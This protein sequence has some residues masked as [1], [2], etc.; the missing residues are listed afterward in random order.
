MTEELHISSIVVHCR[1]EHA[2][3][4]SRQILALNCEIAPTEDSHGRLIVLVER[5]TVRQ[6][7]DVLDTLQALPGVL[8]A[9]LVY[10]HAEPATALEDL[11]P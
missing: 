6:V 5:S 9:L 4:L 8:S 10:H 3:A 7:A 2:D 1:P 11:M